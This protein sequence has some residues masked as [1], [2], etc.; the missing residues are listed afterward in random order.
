LRVVLDTNI[1]ISAFVFPGGAPESAFRMA[2][3]GTIQLVTSPQLLAEFGGVLIR[4][5]GW[6]ADRAENAV[7]LVAPIGLVVTPSAPV[8]VIEDDPDDDRVLEA[9]AAAEV[10]FIVSGDRH[11]LRLGSW[12]GIPIVPISVFLAN[13]PE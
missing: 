2:L 8:Q 5:F 10:D 13:Q 3:E 9:A 1:L 4:K 6:A 7:R 12:S 11:L